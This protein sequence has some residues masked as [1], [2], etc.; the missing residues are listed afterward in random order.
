MTLNFVAHHIKVKKI[1]GQNIGM[2][3]VMCHIT[4]HTSHVTNVTK[5]WKI[6]L[7]PMCDYHLGNVTIPA[8]SWD[9]WEGPPALHRS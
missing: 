3:G 9:H 7:D 4:H 2:W 5:H 6:A 1:V 8:S